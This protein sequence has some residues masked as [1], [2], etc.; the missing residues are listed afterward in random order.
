M[1]A[2]EAKT[3]IHRFVL[4]LER[5][6]DRKTEDRAALACLKR[7][8]GRPLAESLEVLPLL[9]RLGRAGIPE[10][11]EELFFLVATLFPFAP[12]RPR[13]EETPERHRDFGRTL[14]WLAER[15]KVNADGVDRRVTVLLDADRDELPFRLRQAVRMLAQHEPPV[16]WRLLLRHLLAWDSPSR[17]VQKQWARSY[18][19][20]TAETNPEE[21]A[22]TPAGETLLNEET[23]D[24]D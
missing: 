10:R 20:L 18:F 13:A 6:A 7:C 2:D 21:P 12:S 8:A 19:G 15:P 11:S 22:E 23:S 3:Q 4:E 17:W 5:L 24:A 9:Y 16:D 14:R 1:I